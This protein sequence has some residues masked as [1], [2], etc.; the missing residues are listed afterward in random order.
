MEKLGFQETR[1]S[2]PKPRLSE[3]AS[4]NPLS[5]LFPQSRVSETDTRLSECLRLRIPAS[6]PQARLSEPDTRLSECPRPGPI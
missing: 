6:V 5:P 2:E 4:Q 1:V 3:H